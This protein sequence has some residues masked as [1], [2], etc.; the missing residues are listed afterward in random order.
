MI[1]LSKSSIWK[2]KYI[3][4]LIL[5]ITIYLIAKYFVTKYSDSFSAIYF[6]ISISSLIYI[7]LTISIFLSIVL[8][9]I[10]L[11]TWSKYKIANIIIYLFKWILAT[12]IIPPLTVIIVNVWLIPKLQFYQ[13]TPKYKKQAYS[14]IIQAL[15]TDPDIEVKKN[16]VLGLRKI[17]DFESI[18][19]LSE[20]MTKQPTL[21]GFIGQRISK[22]KGT[23]KIDKHRLFGELK[24]VE[25]DNTLSVI[26]YKEKIL[27]E[28][29]QA[30]R[31]LRNLKEVL[32]G[33]RLTDAERTIIQASGLSESISEAIN[34]L[35]LVSKMYSTIELSDDFPKTIAQ[36]NSVINEFD[37]TYGDQSAIAESYSL[38]SDLSLLAKAC[39][40]SA[41][42]FGRSLERKPSKLTKYRH[43][44]T[45]LT[46][47]APDEALELFRKIAR[48]QKVPVSIRKVVILAIGEIGKPD[49][50]QLLAELFDS[51]QSDIRISA[52]QSISFMFYREN[53]PKV[54]NIRDVEDET[55]LY[56]DFENE[57]EDE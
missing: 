22:P 54:K 28:A 42:Q 33:S 13:N 6:G 55:E 47:I 10:E 50:Y 57:E 38:L 15:K 43:I 44:I 49:D 53:H 1:K 16:A 20:E 36:L 3:Y 21:A 26:E 30:R 14:M 46:R 51:P 5:C 56:F 27:R 31:V 41:E 29:S 12:L 34:Q 7:S 8:I 52:I 48:N 40:M 24:Q 18:N 4:L 25:S 23:D 17:G 2:N 19:T 45:M 35:N 32:S 37:N 11:L 39:S 9:I